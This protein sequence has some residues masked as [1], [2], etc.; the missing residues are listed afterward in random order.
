MT[1]SLALMSAESVAYPTFL[2]KRN[3][4]RMN[5]LQEKDVQFWSE[6]DNQKFKSHDYLRDRLKTCEQS[7]LSKEGNIKSLDEHLTIVRQQLINQQQ[8]IPRAITIPVVNSLEEFKKLFRVPFRDVA[9]TQN[10][11]HNVF[12]M[13]VD[14]DELYMDLYSFFVEREEAVERLN[15]PYYRDVYFS[16]S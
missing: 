7:V 16:V 4:K 1:V 2:V 12:G 11:S 13:T 15:I 6:F 10:L 5:E 14:R 3:L 8:P 9:G